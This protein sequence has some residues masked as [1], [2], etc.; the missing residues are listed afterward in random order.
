MY[1]IVDFSI[2]NFANVL[3]NLSEPGFNIKDFK[4]LFIYGS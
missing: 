3:F 1:F 2:K 4:H